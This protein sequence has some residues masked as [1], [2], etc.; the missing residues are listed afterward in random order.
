MKKARANLSEPFSQY[1]YLIFQ[2]RLQYAEP[3]KTEYPGKKFQLSLSQFSQ[4]NY[5]IFFPCA[6]RMNSEEQRNPEEKFSEV[7]SSNLSDW[8]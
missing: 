4:C 1:D 7:F 5:L 3:R 8:I 2:P 6:Q